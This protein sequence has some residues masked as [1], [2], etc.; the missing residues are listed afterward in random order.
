MNYLSDEYNVFS[1]CIYGND[2]KYYY[3]LRENIKIIQKYFPRFLIY[4]YVG[5]QHNSKFIKKLITNEPN[6]KVHYTHKNGV[7]NMIYRHKPIVNNKIKLYFARDCDSEIN[8]RD[9]WCISHF[10][11][12]T[13]YSVHTIRDHY[14]HKSKLSGGLTGFRKTEKIK[15]IMKKITLKFNKF[16][17]QI[18]WEYGS[19]EIFLNQHI[20]PLIHKDLLIHTNI[21][22]FQHEK[23]TRIQHRNNNENFAGNVVVYNNR[24]SKSYKFKY[25][26]FPLQRQIQW[27]FYQQ[28]Y[29]LIS[30]L[31]KDALKNISISKISSIPHFEKIEMFS[32]IFLANIFIKNI[33][34]A[35]ATVREFYQID[36]HENI[37]T[38]IKY[39]Y[40]TARQKK[41]TLTASTDLKYVPG[42]KEIVIYFG[43]FPDDY[44]SLPQSN[45]IYQNISFY[46]DKTNF[47]KYVYNPFWNKVSK[48]YVIHS[49]PNRTDYLNHILCELCRLQT[50][51]N[52]ISVFSSFQKSLEDIYQ[53]EYTSYFVLTTD[54]NLCDDIENIIYNFENCDNGIY[55]LSDDKQNI[56]VKNE[57]IGYTKGT[58]LISGYSQRFQTTKQNYHSIIK[59]K[60]TK[61]LKKLNSYF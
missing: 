34:N 42:H 13:K 25:W 9:I 41:F 10:I 2:L 30:S 53:N 51:L 3:G 57:A 50:P 61:I 19:D 8:E 28:Q 24:K 6:I 36:L 16:K 52:K 43:Q 1:F 33:S 14:Y 38:K 27:L 5:K 60:P 39:F 15:K 45:Q 55:F 26:E 49:N 21:N 31:Y 22:A 58:F 37:K 54:F 20:H 56:Y 7:V 32:Q 29:K 17:S 23:Y 12:Q 48:I 4:I 59:K 40:E 46:S 18:N 35:I 47:T 11:K 44:M